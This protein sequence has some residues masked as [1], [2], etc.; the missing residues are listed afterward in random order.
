MMHDLHKHDL[1]TPATCNQRFE[2]RDAFADGLFPIC[3][4]THDLGIRRLFDLATVLL[5]LDCRPG[6]RV[7]DVGA[8]AGFSSEMLAR[9]GTTWWRS[10]PIRMPLDT[11]GGD[12]A[13]TPEESMEP[14][15]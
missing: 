15:A 1:Q 12:R 13:S 8:G 9:L 11:T 7:L 10:T 14:F 6:D 5:L 4:A 2:A 3:V